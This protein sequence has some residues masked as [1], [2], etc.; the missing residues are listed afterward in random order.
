MSSDDIV[1]YNL[2]IS[3]LTPNNSG[4]IYGPSQFPTRAE[5]VNSS[6]T[7]QPILK[8]PSEYYGSIIKMEW[9]GFTLPIMNFFV[10]TPVSDINLGIYSFTL[11][12][13]G[14]NTPQKFLIFTPEAS[15]TLAP[16]PNPGTATQQMSRYYF[17][18]SV[19]TYIKMLNTALKECVDDINAN[20][21]P[22]LGCSYPF[23]N[24]NPNTQFLEF[25]CEKSFF[26]PSLATPVEIWFNEAMSY[27]MFPFPYYSAN[28]G[29][30]GGKD[31][32]L[33]IVDNMNLQDVSYNGLTYIKNTQPYVD[34]GYQNLVKKI[35]V[36]SNMNITSEIIY[37]NNPTGD[38][39]VL[40]LN[41][42]TD[43]T[44]D[45]SSTRDYGLIAKQFIYNATSLYRVFQMN[46]K[47]PLYNINVA[48]FW[49]DILGNNYPLSLKKG[50]Q[51]NLKFMFIKK[52]VFNK[53]LL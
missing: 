27:V 12:Y 10:Q 39:N 52:S 21:S 43:F 16:P 9:P 41:V 29:V 49:S 15:A 36:T 42:I 17:V 20:T 1:Y 22:S 3:T 23:F 37:V 8:D 2:S 45:V 34:W 48:I 24:Y 50:T 25:Y 51:F 5:N 44:P 6:T 33:S 13:N 35:Y 28:Y 46:D 31:K 53:F 4:V 47:T 40:P 18:Y 11:S 19:E 38:S 32:K 26:S 14:Y 7:T 30:A